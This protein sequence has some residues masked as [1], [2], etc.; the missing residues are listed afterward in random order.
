MGSTRPFPPSMSPSLRR[1]VAAGM[2][3]GVAGALLLHGMTTWDALH[4]GPAGQSAWAVIGT[5]V[6]DLA[7]GAMGGATFAGVFRYQRESPAFSASGG[8]LFGLLWWILGPLTLAPLWG[9][10]GRV[11][12]SGRRQGSSPA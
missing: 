6:V 11:G 12:R 4:S 8:L 7:S 3:A 1:D 9:G 5:S 2:V 10:H